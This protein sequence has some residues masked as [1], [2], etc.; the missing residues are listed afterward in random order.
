MSNKQPAELRS[1]SAKKER[2]LLGVLKSALKL[3]KW[4]VILFD[5]VEKLWQKSEPLRSFVAD[6]FS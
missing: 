1:P 5:W 3:V 6:L 4:C 2:S